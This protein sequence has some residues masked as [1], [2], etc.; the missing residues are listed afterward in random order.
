MGGRPGGQAGRA[1][2]WGKEKGG[3]EQ[4]VVCVGGREGRGARRSLSAQSAVFLKKFFEITF[5]GDVRLC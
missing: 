3:D 4:W 1:G 2:L 5:V